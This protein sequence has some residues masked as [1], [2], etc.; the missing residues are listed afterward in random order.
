M[1]VVP[2]LEWEQA[3]EMEDQEDRPPSTAASSP[4]AGHDACVRETDTQSD[5][6]GDGVDEARNTDCA[7]DAESNRDVRTTSSRKRSRSTGEN[8]EDGSSRKQL[9][10]SSSDGVKA[11]VADPERRCVWVQSHSEMSKHDLTIIFSHFG[12]LERVDVPRPHSG[13]VLF[14]FVHFQEEEDAKSTIR[15]ASDG[16][17]GSLTVKPYQSRRDAWQPVLRSNDRWDQLP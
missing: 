17:F 13:R 9:R 14:A 15:R 3:V 1:R 7:T 6:G 11:G 2:P 10:A 12:L 4:R 5:D 16:E 8:A